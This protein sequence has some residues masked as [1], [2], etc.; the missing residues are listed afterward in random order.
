M[1]RCPGIVDRHRERRSA[2]DLGSGIMSF[3]LHCVYDQPVTKNMQ[4]FD[5]KFWTLIVEYADTEP[6]VNEVWMVET[7]EMIEYQ[8]NTHATAKILVWSRA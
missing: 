7:A 4:D 8:R 3:Y 5:L 6:V 2:Y 1:S